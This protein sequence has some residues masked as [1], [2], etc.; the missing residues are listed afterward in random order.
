MPLISSS[1]AKIV[2]K[3]QKAYNKREQNKTKKI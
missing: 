2:E 1:F 3:D